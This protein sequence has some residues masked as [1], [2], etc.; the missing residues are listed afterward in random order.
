VSAWVT[1]EQLAAARARGFAP[2]AT[3]ADK[4][5][6][7]HIRAERAATIAAEQAARRALRDSGSAKRGSRSAIGDTVRAQRADYFENNVGRFLSIEA[8]TSLSAVTCDE[9]FDCAYTGPPI[10]AE[11]YDAAGTRVGGGNLTAVLDPGVDPNY[12]Q[13]HTLVFRLGNKGDGGVMP[14]TIRVASSNGDSDTLDVREW[15]AQNPAPPGPGFLSGFVTHY[16]DSK[17]RTRRCAT[18]RRSSRTSPRS[19]SCRTRR[20]ATSAR[21]RR[22]WATTRPRRM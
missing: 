6:I 15:I 3:I 20:A 16:N 1:D 8:T 14:A 17:R 12:Y 9:P 2:V 11:W 22:C 5:A 10:A 13:Y 21:R 4:N 18:S 7:D 19:T